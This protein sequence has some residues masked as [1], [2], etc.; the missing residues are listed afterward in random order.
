M[1]LRFAARREDRNKPSSTGYRRRICLFLLLRPCCICGKCWG[2]SIDAPR[3]PKT[4][5]LRLR[6]R[7][8][9][10]KANVACPPLIIRNDID[11]RVTAA[12]AVAAAAAWERRR[13]RSHKRPSYVHLRREAMHARQH[14]SATR[15]GGFHVTRTCM[16]HLPDW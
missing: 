3:M 15:S 2:S 7:S 11:R 1:L 12:A 5:A 6:C 4:D 10:P 8:T 14:C 16:H 13:A 9:T